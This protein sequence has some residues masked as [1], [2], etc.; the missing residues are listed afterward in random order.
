MLK[1]A[2]A[3]LLVSTGLA[4]AQGRPS[5]TGMSCAAAAALVAAV[6][7]VAL[8]LVALCALVPVA[9]AVIVLAGLALYA[10]PF[11]KPAALA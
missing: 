1:L 5:T 6:A 7:L 3:L 11:A 9:L 8:L 4:A 2:S 10:W